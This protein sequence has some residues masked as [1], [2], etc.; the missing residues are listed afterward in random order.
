MEFNLAFEAISICEEQD[1]LNK[2][3]IKLE[4]TNKWLTHL[5]EKWETLYK[6]ANVHWTTVKDIINVNNLTSTTLEIGQELTI[7]TK[8]EPTPTLK[9]IKTWTTISQKS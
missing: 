3:I 1:L 5:V 6:I 9:S 2:A 8:K 4:K 7:P